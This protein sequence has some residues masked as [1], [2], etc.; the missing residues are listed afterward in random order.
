MKVQ[1]KTYGISLP[2]IRNNAATP[3]AEKHIAGFGRMNVAGGNTGP[4]QKVTASGISKANQGGPTSKGSGGPSRPG[5]SIAQGGTSCPKFGPGPGGL[6][7]SGGT[8]PKGV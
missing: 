6:G 5:P 2:G 8:Y 4:T 3:V 7:E 1:D